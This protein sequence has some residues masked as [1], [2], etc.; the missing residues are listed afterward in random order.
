[1]IY[2]LINYNYFTNDENNNKERSKHCILGNGEPDYI[3]FLNMRKEFVHNKEYT[4]Y[5]HT[6][7]RNNEDICVELK[8]INRTV[9]FRKYAQQY[10]NA[11]I[12]ALEHHRLINSDSC[13]KEVM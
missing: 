7:E 11:K 1:M 9:S 4:K 2:K 8:K 5:C 10:N 12:L 6:T 13:V 3:T